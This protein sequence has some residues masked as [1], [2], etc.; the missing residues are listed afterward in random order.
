MKFSI[1]IPTKNA[2]PRF[3]ETLTAIFAQEEKSFEVIAVDSGSTDGTLDVIRGFP[4]RLYQIPPS[5]FGHGRT[6]NLAGKY[7][8]GD[9]VV[10]MS[11]DAMPASPQWLSS[12]IARWDDRVAGAYSRQLPRPDASAGERFFCGTHYP[13]VAT[14]RPRRRPAKRPEEFFFSDVSSCLRRDLL[15]QYPLD[16]S[17]IMSEDHEWAKRIIAAG[18]ATLYE[19]ESAVIHSHSYSALETFKRYFDTAYV[20]KLINGRYMHFLTGKGLLYMARELVYVTANHPRELPAT[21]AADAAK[22]AG[23]F[24]GLYARFLPHRLNRRLSMHSYYWK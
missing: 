23:T 3:A 5:E 18:Y 22:S 1:F 12:F 6:R 8:A 2:G 11:Q 10:F 13:P 7:A 15:M 14:R 4:V 16:D 19:P 9:Y 17:I 21:I 20:L 24:L